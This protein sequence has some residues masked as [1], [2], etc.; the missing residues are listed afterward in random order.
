MTL[1][2]QHA[3]QVV[4]HAVD[5]YL[6]GR[7]RSTFEGE[8]SFETRNSR[9]CLLDGVLW[10]AP[11]SS[12]LGAELVGWL[13]EYVARS[14]VSPTWKPGARAVLVDP[15]N[16]GVKGPHIVVTSAT[17]GLR[18]ERP[19]SAPA[20][21]APAARTSAPGSSLPQGGSTMDQPWDRAERPIV[22]APR[23]SPSWG[24]YPEE[25]VYAAQPP[26]AF[27]PPPALPHSMPYGMRT[28]PPPPHHPPLPALSMPPHRTGTVPPPPM[29]MKPATMPPPPPPPRL[30]PRAVA[31]QVATYPDAGAVHHRLGSPASMPLSRSHQRGMPLR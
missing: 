25:P 5:A 17:R 9:Y 21:R 10:Q 29:M 8:A 28:E 22:P 1:L 12:L 4:R 26:A 2:V 27:P 15:R 30:L 6:D 13:I 16:D 7:L 11:D 19:A 24:H 14:E 20:L 31:P 18:F 3:D 23:P